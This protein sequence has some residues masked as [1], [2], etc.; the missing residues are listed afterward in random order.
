MTDDERQR[1][2]DFIL[3]QQAQSV[4][5]M[6][7]NEE[8]HARFNNSLKQ[9]R[10][11]LALLASQFRRERRDLNE[12]MT[13]LVDAQIRTEEALRSLAATTERNSRAIT[14]L[15]RKTEGTGDG[16]DSPS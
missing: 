7:R 8:E 6:Q 12:R 2:M 5:S 4:A 3:Q 11:I 1:T 9:V 15:S 14:T 16:G 13:A 10:S